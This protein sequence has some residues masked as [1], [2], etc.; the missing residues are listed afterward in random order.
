M[1][2]CCNK[3]GSFVMEH[4]WRIANLKQRT[5]ICEELKDNEVQLRKDQ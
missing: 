4:L 2:V 1:I 3:S 5:D